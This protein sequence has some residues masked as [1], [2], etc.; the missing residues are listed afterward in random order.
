M[1]FGNGITDIHSTTQ[2]PPVKCSSGSARM[3]FSNC[4]N[5][6]AKIVGN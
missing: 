1:N 2:A 4:G 3:R 6:A 5:Q